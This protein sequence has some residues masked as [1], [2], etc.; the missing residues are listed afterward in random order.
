MD[1]RLYISDLDGTL[2]L[3]DKTVSPRTRAVI[4]RFI[5]AGGL[6]TIATG[7]SAA[8]AAWIL[9]ELPLQLDIIAHN[10]AVTVNLQTGRIANLVGLAGVLAR[11]LF[12][13]AVELGL[14]PLCYAAPAQGPTLLVHGAK[15]NPPTQRYLESVSIYHR[16]LVDDGSCLGELS[17]LNLLLLDEPRLIEQFFRLSCGSDQP[18]TVSLGDSAYTPGLGV[19]EVQAVG[20]TKALAAAKLAASLGLASRDLVAFGDNTNDLPLLL[21]A[22]EALCPPQSAAPVLQAVS[23]RIASPAEHG[24]ACYLEALLLGQPATD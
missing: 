15:L 13:E 23:R 8:S 6:F 24:V 18:V 5:A 17:A 20:A 22:G 21:L 10:G 14:S 11:R 2:L 19:G 3:P 1:R 7:R 12:V 16:C 9:R 4:E